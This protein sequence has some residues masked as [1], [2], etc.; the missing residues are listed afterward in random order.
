MF[1]ITNKA[2]DVRKFRDKNSGKD[3]FVEPGKFV[4]TNRPPEENTFWKIEQI[5]EENKDKKITKIKEEDTHDS[6]SS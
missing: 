3:I 2:K 1:K 4:I 6:S 5:S